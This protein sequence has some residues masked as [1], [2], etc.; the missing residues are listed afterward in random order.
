M[1]KANNAQQKKKKWYHYWGMFILYLSIFTIVAVS[2][3][4]CKQTGQQSVQGQKQNVPVITAEAK[5]IA[6]QSI[7][8]YPEIIE[9][10]IVQK[11]N[12]LSLSIIVKYKTSETRAKELGDNFVRMVKT[13]SID[14]NPDQEIGDGIYHYLVGVYYSN[15]EMI[16]MGAKAMIASKITW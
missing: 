2:V 15:Q 10:D 11:D 9:A 4:G 13:F 12:Q 3:S 7:S 8:E 14:K 6:I 1:I 16:A 5:N